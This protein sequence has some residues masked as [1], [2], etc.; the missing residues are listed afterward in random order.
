MIR[1]SGLSLLFLLFFAEPAPALTPN[2]PA[3]TLNPELVVQTRFGPMD[4]MIEAPRPK[5][6]FSATG[7]AVYAI[8]INVV[9]GDAYAVRVLQSSGDHATD[10]TVRGIL[11]HW[12]FRPRSI[13]KLIV[14]V[15]FAHGLAF[16]GGRE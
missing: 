2:F 7:R 1:C 3:G 8:D 6:R 9:R 10:E 15:Q 13:Y 16:W 4:C 14:P 5:K 11:E 12:R